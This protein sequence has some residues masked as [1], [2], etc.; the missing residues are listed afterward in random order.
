MKAIKQLCMWM[1]HLKSFKV[2]LTNMQK[3]ALLLLIVSVLVGYSAPTKQED[4]DHNVESVQQK[5]GPADFFNYGVRFMSK[6]LNSALL[7]DSADD[8][9]SR[10]KRFI[11]NLLEN[12]QDPATQKELFR[13]M[14]TYYHKR[15]RS[16]FGF[17]KTPVGKKFL[18][19]LSKSDPQEFSLV[20][21]PILS[22]IKWD[23]GGDQQPLSGE[24]F[25][26]L[27]RGLMNYF[28]L[29]FEAS[30]NVL[31]RELKNLMRIIS[32]LLFNEGDGVDLDSELKNVISTFLKFF[33]KGFK[34]GGVEGTSD[35]FLG[36]LSGQGG[37]DAADRDSK[38]ADEQPVDLSVLLPTFITSLIPQLIEF[39]LPVHRG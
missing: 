33:A 38:K 17:F 30:D 37:S 11:L 16:S 36:L 10:L 19:L 39:F 18:G 23:G 9:T 24:D 13:I 32:K 22:M 29:F 6:I 28:N 3:L 14:I 21:N 8:R 34:G 5:V 26:N 25:K 31:S 27:M 15:A 2:E 7:K 35:Q 20:L 12:P 4:T 1:Q